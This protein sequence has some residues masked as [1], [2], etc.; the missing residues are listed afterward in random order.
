[1]MGDPSSPCYGWME[2]RHPSD[3]VPVS[4]C[5]APPSRLGGLHEVIWHCLVHLVPVPA[6]GSPESVTGDS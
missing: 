4:P 1:M 3:P 2:P 5:G 6:K